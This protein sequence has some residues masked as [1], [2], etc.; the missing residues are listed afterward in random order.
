VE[1]VTGDGDR[2]ISPANSRILARR[3]PGATLTILPGLGHA[4]P[5]ED[6]RA[7]PLAVLRVHERSLQEARPVAA[8]PKA[9]Q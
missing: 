3:I 6:P 8:A 9:G 1:V 2:I 7:L 4:F 5:L